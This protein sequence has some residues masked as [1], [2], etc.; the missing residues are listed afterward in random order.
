MA[1]RSVFVS[2]KEHAAHS[3][4]SITTN[5]KFVEELPQFEPNQ[6]IAVLGSGETLLDFCSSWKTRRDGST[7]TPMLKVLLL[8]GTK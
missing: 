7:V 1:P 8:L 6:V 3:L 4:M 2:N 5:L